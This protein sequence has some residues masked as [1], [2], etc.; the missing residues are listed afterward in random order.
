[1]KHDM[2]VWAKAQRASLA[3]QS[4]FNANLYM[5]LRSDGF[6][7]LEALRTARRHPAH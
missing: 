1:M 4:A 2:N 5:I 3:S 6:P 7:A